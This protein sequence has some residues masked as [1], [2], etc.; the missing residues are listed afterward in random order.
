M[1]KGFIFVGSYFDIPTIVLTKLLPELH[2]K[3]VK[4][5]GCYLLP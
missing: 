5:R 3:N 2:V 4:K 1:K